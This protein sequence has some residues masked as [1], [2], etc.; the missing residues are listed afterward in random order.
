MDDVLKTWA[1]PSGPPLESAVGGLAIAIEDHPLEYDVFEGP[2]PE[3]QC[4]AEKV[5]ICDSADYLLKQNSDRK[6]GE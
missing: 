2:I 5:A 6:V 1:V 4:G 3:G